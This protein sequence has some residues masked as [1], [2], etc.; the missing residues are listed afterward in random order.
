MQHEHTQT[1][2]AN[3]SEQKT[4]NA[5]NRFVDLYQ[6]TNRPTVTGNTEL[7]VLLAMQK[8][9][10]IIVRHLDRYHDPF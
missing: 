6:K 2:Y 3:S 1:H 10:H 5:D 8:H 7:I 4:K 9:P